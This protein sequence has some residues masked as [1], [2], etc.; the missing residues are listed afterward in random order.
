MSSASDSLAPGFDPVI[1]TPL[2]SLASN[3]VFK[4][5]CSCASSRPREHTR[6]YI[7][8]HLDQYRVPTE[9]EIQAWLNA[10]RPGVPA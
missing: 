9:Q 8:Q 1:G 7:M 4:V 10:T 6:R 2:F 3:E 5:L